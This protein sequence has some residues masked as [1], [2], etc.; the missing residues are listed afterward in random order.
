[1]PLVHSAST[2][3]LTISLNKL[4]AKYH[5]IYQAL[6]VL[7]PTTFLCLECL[8]LF[9][10]LPTTSLTK[11]S[12]GSVV[13]ISEESMPPLTLLL[14]LLYIKLSLSSLLIYI[15]HLCVYSMPVLATLGKLIEARYRLCMPDFSTFSCT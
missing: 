10:K 1:M 11:S 14:E 8:F 13:S 6:S 9:T 12:S 2:Y 5:G 4:Q 15:Y 7:D 3:S